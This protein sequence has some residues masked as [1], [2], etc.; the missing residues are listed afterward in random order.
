MRGVRAPFLLRRMASSW[1]LLASL[2]LTVL[3]TSALLAALASFDARV[4][5]QAAQHQLHSGPQPAI[6]VSGS[7]DAA[8]AA[9]DMPAVSSA[10]RTA[11]GPVPFQL[12]SALW[13][14]PLGLPG[15]AGRG[16]TAGGGA[17]R[18]SPAVRLVQAAAP[19]QIEAH[20]TLTA[21]RWPGPPQPG[22][23][24]AVAL[25][26]AVATQ[27][28]L[29]PGDV[30]AVR[31]RDTGARLRFRVSGVFTLRD[32]ASAYWGLDLIGTSGVSSQPGFTTYGPLVVSAAAFGRGGL[33]VGQASWVAQPDVARISAGQLA[34]AARIN[35]ASSYLQSPDRFGG[36]QVTTGIPALLDGLSR[37]LSVA[38]SLLAISALQLLLLA[39]AALAL[40]ARLLTGHREEENALLSSRGAARWQLARIT[41]AETLLL[42]AVAAAAGAL[43]GGA[44][45]GLLVRAGSLRNARISLVGVPASGWLAAGLVLVLCLVITVWPALRPGTPGGVRVRQGRQ[46]AVAGIARSGGDI[47][48]VV[49][50]LIAVR[51]LRVY[52]AVAH[53]SAGG[54]GID[55]V[56][57]AA[58]A[59]ALAAIS[60]ILLRLLPVTARGMERLVVRTRHLGAALASWEITRRAVRQ[61]GPVLLAV[62]AVA[63][64]TLALAQYQSWGQSARDQ[65]AFSVGAD[66]R[67]DT[68]VPVTVSQAGA[69]RAVP[70]V[71]AAMPVSQV[72][73]GSAGSVLAID[74]PRAA[75]TVLLRPDLAPLPAAALWRL[76]TP[77][78]PGAG[79]AAA[80]AGAALPGRPARLQIVVSVAAAPGTAPLGQIS[81][82][83]EIQD[84]GGIAYTVPAGT[85]RAD[86]RPHALIAELSRTRQASYPLRLLSLSLTYK[87]PAYPAS[88]RAALAARQPDTV[89]IS[90]LAVAPSQ[91]AAFG[92]PFTAGDVMRRWLVTASADMSGL[93]AQ[94]SGQ[95]P[96]LTKWFRTPRGAQRGSFRPGSGPNPV[97]VAKFGRGFPV[98]GLAGVLTITA[99]APARIIAGIATSA[100]LAANQARPGAVI[101]VAILGSEVPVRI[102]GVIS[103]FPTVTG[104][105]LIVDQGALQDYLASQ[106]AAPLPVTQW[107]LRTARG[108]VPGPLP[109]GSAVT[110]RA[111][112]QAALLGNS[113]SAAPL[114]EGLAIAA[115]AAVLA[116]VGFSM[117]VAASVRARRSQTALLAA[118]GYTRWAQA[119]GLCLEELMLTVP[120]ALTGLAAGTGL[121][122]LL[123]PA[124][125]LTAS[126]SAPMP[127]VL[128]KTPI[129]WVLLLTLA[130][131]AAPVAVAAAA[132]LR[133]PD[134]AAQLRAAEAT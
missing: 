49:L 22:Q 125:T 37:R 124:I 78:A 8:I 86:G 27:L 126:A 42:A 66:V 38:R 1:P 104:G 80:G 116:A 106:G 2:M 29:A 110:D 102:V 43:A 36:L 98:N 26:S 59:L 48:L 57:A 13:S 70:G 23:P 55:P 95:E 100:F 93:P 111:R 7:V 61:S 84:A 4:L 117:G 63:T 130:V 41:V 35:R 33:A 90:G 79:T 113:L 3:I 6:D 103:A 101:Q 82:T 47:A 11:F 85:M 123:V 18:S 133:R 77:A 50:A 87:L 81:A 134:P 109:A 74:A 44:L 58:P 64:G 76:I 73:A 69:I 25:P 132:V 54:L 21:G 119:R 115:A 67:V 10:L 75:S 32:L 31:D 91:T 28:R 72:P 56:L 60:V 118:L 83:A 15:A 5:P 129:G 99:K 17:G 97:A 24:I 121:A 68:A 51:E 52:S 34:L 122:H 131:A 92:A 16:G 19:G 120:A 107:W 96:A 94:V 105:A 62:L 53:L 89:T 108:A 112:V 39:A 114:L 12:A 46:A 128:V 20:A 9:A 65:A 14:D 30:L 71:A 45:A 88:A 127:P 40:A